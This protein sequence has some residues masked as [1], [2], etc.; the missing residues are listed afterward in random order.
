MA[1]RLVTVVGVA[2]ESR[3]FGS[4]VRR[5][6]AS[7]C[8]PASTRRKRQSRHAS[9][10]IPSW[11]AVAAAFAT[12]LIALPTGAAIAEIVRVTDPIAM[13]RVSP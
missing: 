10:A 11:P 13:W 12:I 3:V 5:K 6:P 9:T 8:R 2:R 1:T 4:P 7:S